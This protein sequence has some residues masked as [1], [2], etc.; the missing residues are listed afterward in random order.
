MKNQEEFVIKHL[1][2][3]GSISRNFCLQNFISRL[4]AIICDLNKDGWEIEGAFTKSPKGKDYVYRLKNSPLT[5]VEYKVDGKVVG[6]KY[7]N[8]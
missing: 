7:N 2:E 8:K 6:V 4:G 5:R 1:M 3:N